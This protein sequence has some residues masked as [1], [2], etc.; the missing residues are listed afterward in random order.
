MGYVAVKGGHDAIVH[1]EK[2]I[3]YYRVKALTEPVDIAQIQAQ[4]RLALDK[5]M[6]EGGLYDPEYAA[7]AFKQAQGDVLEGAFILRAFRATLERK[8]YAEPL[9]TEEMFVRRR[10]SAAFREIQGGQVLGPTPDYTQRM[11]DTH[12]ATETLEDFSSFLHRFTRPVNGSHTVPAPSFG[13]VIHVLR[14]EGLL[15][16]VIE[17][18]RTLMDITRNA[19]KFPAP[20]SARLQMLARAETGGIMAIAYSSMR[21]FEGAHPTVGELR[22][23]KVKVH[24][25]DPSGR[26]RYVGRIAV[27]EAEMITSMQITEKKGVPFFSIGYGLCFGQN[28]TKAICMGILD[29]TLRNTEGSAPCNDQEFVL[30]HTDGVD[31]MGFTN[32]L[33]LPHYVTFQSKLDNLRRVLRERAQMSD[34]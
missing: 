25:K 4:F 27:T 34:P 11:L 5:I 10:I 32:H 19:V 13:K 24:L 18:D 26:R 30:Y 29:R 21:G 33:K 28:D 14:Q 2:L 7:I 15:K 17:E 20:R 8:F 12:L 22:Y 23:G 9:D 16:P 6:G 1:A 31:A 3:N